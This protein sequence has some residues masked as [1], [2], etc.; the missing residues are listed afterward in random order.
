VIY[1]TERFEEAPLPKYVKPKEVAEAQGVNERTLRRW[2]GDG[3][4]EAIRTPSGQRRYNIE[5]YV[6]KS[7]RDKRKVVVYAR[8]SGRAQQS[9]LNRL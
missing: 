1:Y 8:V 4:I 6:V 9:D 5:S 2:E 3:R 7:G